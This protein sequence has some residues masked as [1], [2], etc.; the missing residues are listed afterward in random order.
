MGA[1]R[2]GAHTELRVRPRRWALGAV[3]EQDK[4]D[5][6]RGG[7]LWRSWPRKDVARRRNAS[8]SCLASGSEGLRMGQP[9][10]GDTGAPAAEHI[11]CQEGTGGTET[12]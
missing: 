9:A 3:S 5:Q 10:L 8:G 11:G 7:C 2:E 1:G 12:S 4:E 6:A